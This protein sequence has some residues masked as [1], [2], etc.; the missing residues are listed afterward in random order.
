MRLGQDARNRLSLSLELNLK[1][2]EAKE[3][4]YGLIRQSDVFME[5]MVW[6]DKLGISDDALLEVNPK[7]VIVHVSGYGNAKF[8]G[9]P[10]YCDG[11][12]YDMIGQAFSGFA[13]MNGFPD[14]D[15]V[16]AKPWTNDYISAMHT[17]FAAMAGVFHAK[18]TG[19]GC[20]MDV[21]QFE[22]NARWL[23]H[24]FTHYTE[25]GVISERAGNKAAVAQP[26]DVFH[27][28]DKMVV[29]GAFGPAVYNRFI[30][31]VGFDKEYFNWKDCTSTPQAIA[32]EKGL[33]LDAKIREWVAERSADEVFKQMLVQGAM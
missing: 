10:E 16:I 6:L 32:S 3:I 7:L 28:K 18:R 19:Q 30:Q 4:F 31:A 33:E 29:I 2:P 22:S 23:S 14:K 12:S 27:A 13:Y 21:A 9:I 8:G 24:A 5:N 20:V 11:A 1:Y 25:N 17:L 15:P 26:Y